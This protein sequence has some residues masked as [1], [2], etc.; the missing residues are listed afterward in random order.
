MYFLDRSG[1]VRILSSALSILAIFVV[2]YSLNQSLNQGGARKL[3]VEPGGDQDLKNLSEPVDEIAAKRAAD[4]K[5]PPPEETEFAPPE[6]NTLDKSFVETQEV[7]PDTADHQD[8]VAT[9]YSIDG[10]TAS[11][12]YTRRGVIAADPRVLP[13]GTVVHIRSGRYT[14][15]YTV[16]DTGAKIK[17]RIVDIYIPSYREAKQF[18]R[19]KVKLQVLGHVNKFD[20]ARKKTQSP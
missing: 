3:A 4:H 18:G 1:L 17:G 13:L 20:P 5:T 12:A 6:A 19:R 9:A 7:D 11:G 2:A 14:G 15:R 10:R 16:L 8:F